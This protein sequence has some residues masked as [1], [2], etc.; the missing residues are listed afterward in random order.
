MPL[1]PPLPQWFP[2]HV[3]KRFGQCSELVGAP[4]QHLP[5]GSCCTENVRRTVGQCSEL[6]GAPPPPLPRVV[7]PRKCSENDRNCWGHPPLY[8]KTRDAT[9]MTLRFF[10]TPAM[11][12]LPIAALPA[13]I[14]GK[15]HKATRHDNLIATLPHCQWLPF[16]PHSQAMRASGS[17]KQSGRRDST[18]RAKL[19][20]S[21]HPDSTNDG[22]F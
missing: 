21:P 1:P 22:L 10:A 9:T 18:G 7:V 12:D 15:E 16:L 2:R 11:H 3:R 4:P 13:T 6:P 20:E 19:N 5:R 14:R 8:T 17:R